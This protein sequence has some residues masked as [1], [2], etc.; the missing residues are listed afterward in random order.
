MNLALHS[1]VNLPP[2]HGSQYGKHM[3]ASNY[4]TAQHVLIQ[5][6]FKPSSG[7]I[8]DYANSKS[9]ISAATRESMET[10]D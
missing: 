4:P 8:Q 7:I 3:R 6:T 5:S 2:L 10:C 1:R 9:F